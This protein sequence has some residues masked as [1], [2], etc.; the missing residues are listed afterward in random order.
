ME[1][2]LLAPDLGFPE[3]P[4]V[5]ADGS[6]VICDGNVGQLLRWK[7]GRI[8]TH[9]VT[10]GSPWGAILGSDGAIYVTQGGDV[11]GS[12]DTSAIPG[13]QRVNVDGSVELLASE[14]AGH[15]LA[16]PNDLA[17]G[18]DG[19]LWFTDSATEQEPRAAVPQPGRLFVLDAAGNGELVLERPALTRRRGA[20]GDHA[21]RARHQLHLR[22]P[23]AVRDRNRGRRD[24]RRSAH[25]YVL[26]G[27]DRRDGRSAAAPRPA[28]TG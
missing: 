11:P 13:I 17:F 6:I 22:R 5:M 26:A 10:G 14:I 3:G 24:P 8:S 15:P 27:R 12:G 18:P 23:D 7:D 2:K 1:A 20:G 19:R 9:A 25:R 28:L 16:G 21:G 4:T